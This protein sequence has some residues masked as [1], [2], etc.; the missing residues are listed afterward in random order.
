[1]KPS[2]L[3]AD[4]LRTLHELEPLLR[5]AALS[6][7]YEAAQ[8]H[9]L[10][11]QKILRPTGHETRLMQAKLWLFEAAMEAGHLEV[12]AAG[13]VGISKKVAKSTRTYIE[14]ITLLA[15]CHL[16]QKQ[17]GEAAP[18][19]AEVL[20]RRNIRPESGR[21]SFLRR[22]VARFEEEGLLGALTARNPESLDP[23]EIQALA[24]D[25]VRTKNED[26]ILFEMGDSLPPESVAFLLKVDVMAKR[27]LTRKEVFYLPGEAQIMEKAELG[28]TAFRSFKRVL[29][30]SLCDPESD[31]YKAW[32]SSGLNFVLERR[33]LGAAIAT[34]LL[35]LGVGIKALAVSAT[36]LVMKFGIEVYCDR[37]KPDLLMEN[38]RAS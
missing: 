22:A 14:A 27:G 9:A 18:Y 15:I 34:A 24:A 28:R 20:R 2:K 16:R 23:E 26:E 25:L 21:R 29:W 7:D 4:Q 6:G 33:Y 37:F 31:I 13:F 8:Q 3:T 32:F 5:Q 38:R 35:H 11:I 17:L 10:D 36:A 1:M 19:I 30:N 12:A